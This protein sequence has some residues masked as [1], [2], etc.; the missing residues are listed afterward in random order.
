MA[1]KVLDQ[2]LRADFGFQHILWIYS[3]RRGVHCWVCDRNARALSN[4]TRAAVVEY[5]TVLTG[6]SENS[7][8]RMKSAFSSPHPMIKRAYELLEPY[9]ERYIVAETGQ[10][11][12]GENSTKILSTLPSETVRQTLM[13]EWEK[14]GNRLSSEHKWKQL[15]SCCVNDISGNE[16]KNA[17]NKKFK[18]GPQVDL[19]AWR[20]ELVFTHTYPRLDANVSKAQNHLLKSPFCIHPKT[21]RVCVPIDP[22]VAD[23][24]DPFSVPTVRMLCEEVIN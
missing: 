7:D 19:E 10:N 13:D 9:F 6:S 8:K 1:V 4:E 14:Y 17:T 3:G 11:L 23:D 2:T 12:F 22:K 16:N 20:M 18:K 5:L 21:G 15:K 24:F